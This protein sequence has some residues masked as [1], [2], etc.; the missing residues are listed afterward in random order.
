MLTWFVSGPTD[1]WI[2]K[3]MVGSKHLGAI[4]YRARPIYYGL[5]INCVI[6]K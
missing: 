5:T 2:T 6:S 3:L 1:P 4:L